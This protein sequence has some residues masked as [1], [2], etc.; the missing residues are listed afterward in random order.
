[1]VYTLSTFGVVFSALKAT[2][3]GGLYSRV[4]GGV[5]GCRVVFK[6]R[7]PLNQ[8]IVRLYNRGVWWCRFFTIKLY[9][10]LKVST[11]YTTKGVSFVHTI[12]ILQDFTVK[13]IHYRH[14]RRFIDISCYW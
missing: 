7:H 11:E 10:N 5:G 12:R 14:H 9:K 3:A 13:N 1:M 6:N 4:S 2:D 8:V